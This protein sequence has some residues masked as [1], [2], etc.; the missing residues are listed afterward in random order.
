[1]RY[2]FKSVPGVARNAFLGHMKAP[3]ALM[4][5][6]LYAQTACATQAFDEAA[7]NVRSPDELASWL[8]Q[9]FSYTMLV[10]GRTHSPDETI[11]ARTGDCDDFAVLA[12]AMLTKMGVANEVILIR[13]KKLSI[14]HAICVW[15]NG[16]GNYNFISNRELYRSGKK[17]IEEL[18]KKYYPDCEAIASI[19]PKMY[20]DSSESLADDRSGDRYTDCQPIVVMDPRLFHNL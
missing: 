4:A 17:T 7:M 8:S 15:K 5:L 13:F 14:A 19:D 10:H 2:R 1:M 20:I 9:E 6:M 12:S 3:A 16:D 18:V 11:R